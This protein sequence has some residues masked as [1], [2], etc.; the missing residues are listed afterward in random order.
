MARR[1]SLLLFAVLFAACGAKD[2][3]A[4]NPL[5]QETLGRAHSITLEPY[6]RFLSRSHQDPVDYVLSLFDHA[7]IVILCERWHMEMTQYDFIL[8]L[9]RDHRF[10]SKVGNVFTEIGSNSLTERGQGFLTTEGLSKEDVNASI[11][12][13][14][15][16]L[17]F[18]PYW[19]KTN[20]SQ[21]L[22]GLY[23]INQTLDGDRKLRWFPVDMPIDWSTMTRERYTE[24]RK[25]LGDRDR[26]MANQVIDR[27]GVLR[28]SKD[29][30]QKA[31]VIMNYR[32]AFAPI[33]FVD[34]GK[35]DNVGRYLFEAF[36]GRV[37]N[38]LLNTVS[39]LPGA[40][41]RTVRTSLIHE[42]KWDAAFAVKSN[43]W[44]G[45]ALKGSP[46][47]EDAFDLFPFREHKARYQD[48]F[49]GFVFFE[50][51]SSHRMAIGIPGF[52]GDDFADE[53]ARRYEVFRG[54][55]LPSDDWAGI[56]KGMETVREY[57]YDDMDAEEWPKGKPSVQID[58]WFS[59]H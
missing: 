4:G 31:L 45:F 1:P 3:P 41:D 24:F 52:I 32:H 42:G 35:G 33:D 30:R 54:E 5:P 43:P 16:D 2:V 9:V 36:P 15:R 58:R 47:G 26:I 44:V 7:D 51:L 46:F 22:L 13:I 57:R 39:V 8:S 56:K 11:V 29:S 28:A 37:A 25:T 49:T 21:F 6:L 34:G 38:V 23:R 55:K 19:E 18:F 12:G 50:P 59:G 48:V 40:D 20:F 14:H 10:A 53:Y 27:L 17:T